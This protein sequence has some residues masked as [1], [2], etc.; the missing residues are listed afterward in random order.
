MIGSAGSEWWQ[1]CAYPG[2]CGKDSHQNSGHCLL[3][4][5]RF[6]TGVK[7]VMA[8]PTHPTT[9]RECTVKREDGQEGEEVCKERPGGVGVPKG[10][11]QH[12]TPRVG[13]RPISYPH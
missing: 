8:E 3:Q 10:P 5:I 12:T 4:G 9:S 13:L 11:K 1:G 6:W 7:M 2:P